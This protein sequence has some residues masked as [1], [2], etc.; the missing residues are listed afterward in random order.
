MDMS[1]LKIEGQSEQWRILCET[2]NRDNFINL[3]KWL[4]PTEGRESRKNGGVAEKGNSPISG[5]AEDAP[6]KYSQVPIELLAK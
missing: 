1:R 6:S 4:V 2:P 3:H 5:P